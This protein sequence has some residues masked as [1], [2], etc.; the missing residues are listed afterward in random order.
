MTKLRL[1]PQARRDLR[2]I[3][4]IGLLTFGALATRKHMGG[5]DRIFGLLRM[6]PRA[7]Q[8]RPEYGRNIRSFSHHP[9]RLIY[10][11]DGSNILIVR[12]LH[13]ARDVDDAL[14]EGD[15]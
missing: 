3:Q 4:A 15:E 11:L 10:Q 9:H 7:G 5:F 14:A 8:S 1:T 13:F 6:H 2:D 12:I